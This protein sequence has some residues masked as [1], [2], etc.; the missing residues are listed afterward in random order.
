MAAA[1]W[2]A[3]SMLARVQRRHPLDIDVAAGVFVAMLDRLPEALM[4]MD[5]DVSNERIVSVMQDVVQR[6]LFNGG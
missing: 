1:H 3:R 5:A 2:A 4:E 6:A